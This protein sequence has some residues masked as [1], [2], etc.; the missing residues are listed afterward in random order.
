MKRSSL[1]ICI[2]ALA[3]P[4][5]QAA[6]AQT[7]TTSAPQRVEAQ[8]TRT[9]A[10]P[11]RTQTRPARATTRA[12]SVQPRTMQMT[13]DNMMFDLPFLAN[14]LKPGERYYRRKSIHTASETHPQHWGYDLS[15]VRWDNDASEWTT[16]T[17]SRSAYNDNPTNDKW[18]A[19]G[20]NVYAV[21]DG[22]VVACWRNAPENPRPKVSGDSDTTKPWLHAKLKSD[23]IHHGGNFV[24]IELSD[25]SIVRQSHFIPGSVPSEICPHDDQYLS[26]PGADSDTEVTGGATISAGQLLG[27]LGNAGNSTNPHLHFHREDSGDPKLMRFRRGLAAPLTG[28]KSDIDN[29]TRFAGQQIPPGK[30]LIWPPRRLSAEY[31][32]FKFPEADFGRMFDHLADSGFWPQSIDGYSVNGKVFYNF[33]WTPAPGQWKGYFGQTQTAFNNKLD[34]MKEAGFNPVLIESYTRNNQVRYAAVYQKGKPGQWRV[35]SNRT[36]A[37]HDAILEQAKADGLK[38]VN[39]SVVS[40]N[41]ARR[42]TALYRSDSIGSWQLKSQ[43]KESDYQTVFNQNNAAGRFPRY[44]SAYKHNG[45]TYFS[46]I[47]ASKPNGP[48]K[49]RHLM[50]GGQLQSEFNAAMSAGMRTKVITSFDGA[51]SQHRYAAVWRK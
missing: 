3:T 16:Y 31:T 40:I 7:R 12:L 21:A 27:R 17:T 15:A 51:S 34:Q 48:G 20:K 39:V 11:T 13:T 5:T 37:Q 4:L 29:W 41:G 49:A 9:T 38:P 28:E 23:E 30:T 8:P 18:I 10:T 35:R 42:Y 25:G 6:L 36:T 14:D 24:Q 26:A 22:V 47:F 32:R 46:A 2:A 50:T 1:L 44:L 19:Y 45:Q 43:I 33:V